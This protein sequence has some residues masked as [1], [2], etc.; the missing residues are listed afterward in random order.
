MKK[1][2]PQIIRENTD[3]FLFNFTIEKGFLTM[4]QNS[5]AIRKRQVSLTTF[6]FFNL[7][8]KNHHKQSLKETNQLG[9]TTYNIHHRQAANIP[10]IFFKN[11]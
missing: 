1:I 10:S 3:E 2:K 9:K 5:E 7:H 8:G 6:F 4:T 11:L